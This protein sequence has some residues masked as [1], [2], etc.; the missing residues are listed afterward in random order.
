MADLRRDLDPR[1]RLN[2][3]F[4]F[5][6]RLHK[7]GQHATRRFLDG[8]FDDIGERSTIDDMAEPPAEVA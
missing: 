4:D 6:E 2:N 1:S 8:H 3:D 7:L 5:F